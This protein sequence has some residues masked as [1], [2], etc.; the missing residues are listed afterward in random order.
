[1]KTGA[2]LV[3]NKAD[4]KLD[5]GNYAL[6]ITSP[7]SSVSIGETGKLVLIGES[8][9]LVINGNNEGLLTG[10]Y[11]K[12]S[13]NSSGTPLQDG[14]LK[15]TAG[16]NLT[17]MYVGNNEAK[18]AYISKYAPVPPEPTPTPSP[19]Q[20]VVKDESCEKVIGPTWHWNNDKGI[21][22]DYGVV[23]TSTK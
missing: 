2:N 12:T 20:P 7:T 1:M 4:I 6:S 11:F 15:Y 19:S 14:T 16:D 21:C 9:P 13:E 23:G 17:R 3:I 10:Y 5:S 18:Y 8:N 22:E